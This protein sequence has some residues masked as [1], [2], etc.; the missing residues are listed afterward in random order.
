MSLTPIYTNAP[1]AYSNAV[2]PPH[3]LTAKTLKGVLKVIDVTPDMTL[4][5]A[6]KLSST[7]LGLEPNVRWIYT[8][9]QMG[10]DTSTLTQLNVPD[11]A[12]VL[13][14]HHHCNE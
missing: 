8:G 6:K 11:N 14:L 12:T 4:G 7:A 1:P 10:P 2:A 9:K 5:D 13:S 3:K